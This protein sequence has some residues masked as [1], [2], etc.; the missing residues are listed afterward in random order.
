MSNVSMKMRHMR[1]Y[2]KTK[3][4]KRAA[5]VL[6]SSRPKQP[7]LTEERPPT[8]PVFVAQTPPQVIKNSCARNWGDTKHSNE[9]TSGMNIAYLSL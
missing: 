9:P 5:G 2:L 1:N 7:R 8:E 4:N 3:A 6:T